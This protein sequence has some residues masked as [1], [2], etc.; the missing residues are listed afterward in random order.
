MVAYGGWPIDDHYPDGFY[1][2]GHPN[3]NVLPPL[4]Y[5]VPYRALYSRNVENLY[6]AGRN[7]SMTHMAMSSMRVMATCAL[8]GQ[9]VGTA[10]ALA[11]K[12][13]M[14]PHGIFL[15]RIPELQELLM[16]ADC[17]LPAL[18]R[19][20]GEACRAAAIV[21]AGGEALAC[22][23]A[24][25][26]GRDRPNIHY[27]SVECGTLLPNGEIA[28]YRFPDP[29]RVEA[30]HLT[31][32]SDLNRATLPGDPCERTHSTRANVRLDS[33]VFYLPLTLIKAFRLEVDT[34]EGTELLLDVTENVLRSYH[35]PVKR[36]GVTALRLI[37]LENYGKTSETRVLSFDFY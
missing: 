28:E 24:L 8:L 9:A 26:D 1:H 16:E 30:V 25:K 36:D 14:T 32:D 10:A 3:T 29:I 33:P 37:P 23:E 4:P 6:F 22:G 18:C 5:A 35:V 11:V 34:A 31:F 20:V 12:E 19:R 21:N 13:R 17:F 7:I 15:S 2:K 27:A